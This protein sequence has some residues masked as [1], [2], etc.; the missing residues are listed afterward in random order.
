MNSLSSTTETLLGSPLRNLVAILIFMAVVMVAATF[1]YLSAGWSFG[2]A[3]YMVVLTVYS[4]GYGEVRPIDT[5]FLHAVTMG[6]MILGCTGMILLTGALV[7]L[8]TTMQLRAMFGADR[9]QSRINALSGHVIVCGFGRIGVTLAHEL[10]IAGRAF[11]IV[12]RNAAKLAEAEAAGHL[13]VTGDATDEAALIRAGVDRAHILATVLPDD[14]ANVFITLSARSL[15]P[16]LEI[17][18][19]GELPTTEGKLRHAGANKVVLPTHI[20]AER[21]AEMILYPETDAYVRGSAHLLDVQ[22]QLRMLGLDL[23]MVKVMDDGLLAGTLVGDAERQGGGR[24][25]IVEVHRVNGEVLPRPSGDVRVQ[26][27]DEVVFVARGNSAGAMAFLS[28]PKGPIRAG[29][30][31][32]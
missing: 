19:R 7:Q 24:F 17:I 22:R 29:R 4:V 12:E 31:R 26:P 13:C 27:G 28:G 2:D 30:N 9:M 11:V 3:I 32:F 10:K 16:A 8:F 20:G 18:A 5:P 21:I 25:F 23:E 14:A 1:G 6:T 15:N